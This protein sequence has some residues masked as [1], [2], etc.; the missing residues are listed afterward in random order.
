MLMPVSFPK[1]T[2]LGT[3]LASIVKGLARVCVLVHPSLKHQG[4]CL[5]IILVF[6]STPPGFASQAPGLALVKSPTRVFPGSVVGGNIGPDG[7]AGSPRPC[8]AMASYHRPVFPQSHPTWPLWELQPLLDL[9]SQ[10]MWL[11]DGEEG[12][13]PHQR[14]VKGPYRAWSGARLPHECWILLRWTPIGMVWRPVWNSSLW[15]SSFVY[16]KGMVKYQPYPPV[17]GI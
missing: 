15:N 4:S 3:A 10:G 16:W 2:W 9:G 14:Q 6:L 17:L 7:H 1:N 12:R 5:E 13:C 11:E 8:N